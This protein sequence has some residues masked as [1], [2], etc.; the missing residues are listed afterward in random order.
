M[1]YNRVLQGDCIKLANILND[2]SVSLVVCSPPYAMQRKGLYDGINEVEY[3]SWT[4]Q[5][6]EALRPK[7]KED[8]SVFI[9]IREHIRNG[10]LS[11]YVLKTRLAVRESNWIEAETLIWHK[12]DAPP[13]GS[14]FRP[15]R[16]W[17][18][19]LWYSKSRS[20]FLDL[21]ACGNA[22]STRTGGF[23]GSKRFGEGG[24]SP[25]AANQ[26]RELKNGTSRCSDVVAATIGSIESGVAHPAMYPRGVPNFLIQTFSRQG[27]L[28]VDPFS[29]SGQTGLSAQQLGRLFLGFEK[30][31]E[32]C[33]I[34][35]E[36]LNSQTFD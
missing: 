21:K 10:E 7:L 3:P 1:E 34:A 5:W 23:V 20:P 26:S 29:G 32:Y 4:V 16:N 24:D 12:P 25:L 30:S 27:D 9:V 28:V 36:R 2:N 15:R 35:N 11:D 18:Y 8:A 33:C 19:I 31:P 6:M 17:E 14:Y 13:L 22:A